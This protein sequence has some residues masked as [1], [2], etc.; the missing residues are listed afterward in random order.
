MNGFYTYPTS[1]H[2]EKLK[3][4]RDGE[5]AD[6]R[7]YFHVVKTDVFP[8][9][10]VRSCKIDGMNKEKVEALLM[11][12][13]RKHHVVRATPVIKV[14]PAVSL[15]TK[16]TAK[17]VGRHPLFW[18]VLLLIIGIELSI[19]IG[20]FLDTVTVVH[21]KYIDPIAGPEDV[22]EEEI[23]GTPSFKT[24]GELKVIAEGKA[25]YYDSSDKGCLG[26]NKN[27]IMSNGEKLDDADL[28]LAVPAEW[29]LSGKVKLNRPGKCPEC[30]L[31]RVTNLDNGKV[32]N[33]VR[34]TD[35]GGFAKYGRVA[36]LSVA[37]KDILG[38]KT[39]RST[40]RIEELPVMEQAK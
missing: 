21:A 35:T 10:Y 25:S 3:N 31:V 38:V 4:F 29:V 7:H 37:L 39:D 11:S 1:K 36:D 28:T 32:A 27:K 2:P 40:I 9:V 20:A 8:Y 15:A 26:C 17:K 24:T 14:A 34:I 16:K 33:G 23:S 18:P 6:L 12:I 5:A 22:Q 13:W 19:I 30:G